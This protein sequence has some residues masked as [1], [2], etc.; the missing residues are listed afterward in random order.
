MTHELSRS[1]VESS[2]KTLL[3]SALLCRGSMN[4]QSSVS[5]RWT[6]IESAIMEFIVSLRT[7]CQETRR[8]GDGHAKCC[9]RKHTP[10]TGGYGSRCPLGPRPQFLQ[11]VL[12]QVR[13]CLRSRRAARCSGVGPPIEWMLVQ[14]PPH[15][16]HW[17]RKLTVSG[18]VTSPPKFTS[19][20]SL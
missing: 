14:Y 3:S 19:G 8:S 4:S 9:G 7:E 5:F 15:I 12:G 1:M 10:S 18:T 16:V 13:T 20:M 17:L 6:V 11:I 2:G